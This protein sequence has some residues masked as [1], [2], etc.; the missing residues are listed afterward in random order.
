MLLAKKVNSCLRAAFGTHDI[1]LIRR[2]ADFAS[3]EGF[4]KKDFEVQ[5]LYG[6][7]RTEQERLASEGCTSIVL[8]AYGGTTGIRGSCAAW[9]NGRRIYG[10]WC[11]T[12]SRLS[13]D[14]EELVN[15]SSSR[16]K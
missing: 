16:R 14:P 12:F 11:A 2:L 10:S 15:S 6:I 13:Q 4:T 7:Q 9:R 5:M 3:A 8:V 1:L